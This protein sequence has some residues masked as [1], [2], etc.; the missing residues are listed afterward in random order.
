MRKYIG[1]DAH[2]RYSILASVRE[3]GQW[4][5]PVRVEHNQLSMELCL[6]QLPTGTPVP[7]WRVQAT[8]IGWCER[9]KRRYWSRG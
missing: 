2:A 4:D 6:K 3:D 7:L 9:W 8:G 1:C 5:A